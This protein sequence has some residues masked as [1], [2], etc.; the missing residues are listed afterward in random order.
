MDALKKIKSF[1]RDP[2]FFSYA[3][4]LIFLICKMEAH[5]FVPGSFHLF[6]KTFAGVEIFGSVVSRSV[7][8]N[9]LE[10]GVDDGTGVIICELLYQ[11]E[12]AV[13]SGLFS[14]ACAFDN[15]FS[16]TDPSAFPLTLSLITP[17]YP[18][19]S[20]SSNFLPRSPIFITPEDIT[21][22][23]ARAC[24][25]SSLS[26]YPLGAAV[27]VRGKLSMYWDQRKINIDAI[28]EETDV[29]ALFVHSLQCVNGFTPSLDQARSLGPRQI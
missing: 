4:M 23:V 10:L 13:T 12:A 20:D 18:L 11:S 27:C 9:K 2:I 19:L 29:H 7:R 5:P 15:S 21:S 16:L 24:H 1:G 3:K 25:Q 28:H 26:F 8:K 17:D 22:Q 6:G 14:V